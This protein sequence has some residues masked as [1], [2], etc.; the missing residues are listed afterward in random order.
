MVSLTDLHLRAVRACIAEV[1]VPPGVA[2]RVGSIHLR[3]DQCVS[4]ARVAA[5]LSRHGGCLLADDVGRGKT[6]VALAVARS[7]TRSLLIVPASL[8]SMWTQAMRRAE[9]SCTLVTHEAMSRGRLPHGSYDGIIVDE[10]HRFRS[11]GTRRY[12]ALVALSSRTPLL[13]LSATPLQNRP[14]DLASQIALFHGTRAFALDT[15][16]LAVFIVRGAVGDSAGLPA[17]A[18]PRWVHSVADDSVVLESILALPPP[19]R[20]ADGGDAG[21]LRTIGLVRAW[22]SS[23]AALISMLRRRRRV[24]AAIEQ[25]ANEGLVPT[26]AELRDW[27]CTDDAIQLGFASVLASG[28]AGAPHAAAL[29]LSVAQEHEGLHRLERT[30]AACEDPDRARVQA[31]RDIRAAHAD[32]CV[33]AFTERESTARAFYA[34]LGADPGVGLLTSRAA[35]IA[36]GSL[37]RAALLERFA[38]RAHGTEVPGVRERVTLLIATDLL[39]EGVNLQDASIVVHLDLPWNPARLAQRVGRVRRPGGASIVHSYLIAP[40]ARTELLLDVERRLHRKLAEAAIVI[41]HAIDVLPR[42][43]T[44]P[45]PAGHDPGRAAVLGEIAERIARWTRQRPGR[46]R[47][48]RAPI[49]VGGVRA[50]DVGWLAALDDGR[51]I[52]A[53]RGAAP[54]AGDSVAEASRWCD[55]VSR[56]LDESEARRALGDCRRWLDAEALARD[57]G[58]AA[59]TPA[60]DVATE[61]RIARAVRSAP[62]HERVDV[63]LRATMLRD[64]LDRAWPIGAELALRAILARSGDGNDHAW[65][66]DAAAL[67]ASVPS[68]AMPGR[69]RIVALVI[70]GPDGGPDEGPGRHHASQLL[71][72]APPAVEQR[73]HVQPCPPSGVRREHIQELDHLS[74]SATPTCATPLSATLASPSPASASAR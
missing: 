18:P 51:V 9:I 42:I 25:S 22:A 23:R 58:Q 29:L 1:A 30:I 2:T 20:P 45:E 3:R 6:Y 36:S 19:A 54:D 39:S 47:R 4:A 10:S 38:P 35:R 50:L 68:R 37:S 31:L 17:V 15:P 46:A 21:V 62:R 61:R 74:D 55:G 49:L 72:E 16:A 71:R 40:P 56:P 52:A 5:A 41:G 53:L 8:R 66:V 48:E 33:L 69:S 26:R 70:L 28:A 65:L 44:L 14:R 12:A 67:A 64:A 59:P 13:L 73:R 57:C 63:A 60:L 27:H 34:M 24:A 7:W 11:P 43:V 32:E